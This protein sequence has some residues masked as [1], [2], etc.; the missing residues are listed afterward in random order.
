MKEFVGLSPKCYVFLCT[1]KVDRNTVQHSR[2]VEKETA[3]GVKRKV[4]D[5]HLYFSH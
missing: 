2:A 1:G 3:K 5:E 4:K